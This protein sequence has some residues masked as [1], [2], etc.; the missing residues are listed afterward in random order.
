MD[1]IAPLL[2]ANR[3]QIMEFQYIGPSWITNIQSIHNACGRAKPETGGEL[4]RILH[5]VI[6]LAPFELTSVIGA[7][8]SRARLEQFLSCGAEESAAFQILPRNIGCMISKSPRGNSMVT[9]SIEAYDLE[10]TFSGPSVLIALTGA[11]SE[12]I[13]EISR[14]M[15]ENVDSNQTL[16]LN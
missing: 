2:K 11:L 13:F 12:L 9:V 6:S 3:L 5:D 16:H 8:M 4:I 15:M 1:Q 10:H 14:I 7:P